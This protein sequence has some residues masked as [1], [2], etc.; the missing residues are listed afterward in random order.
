[1]GYR[2]NSTIVLGRFRPGPNLGQGLGL[3]RGC[4]RN[5]PKLTQANLLG[6]E[7]RP[8]E[9]S[10]TQDQLQNKESQPSPTKQQQQ[11]PYGHHILN[12]GF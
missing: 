8:M 6:L 9:N 7:T 11:Q 1:M 2:S 10:K 3:T 12:P 4:R 5:Y